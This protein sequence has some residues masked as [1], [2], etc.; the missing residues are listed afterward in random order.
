[1]MLLL[2]VLL[3]LSFAGTE[4]LT[5]LESV[6]FIGFEG[7]RY[8]IIL[9]MIVLCSIWGLGIY[10]FF[11]FR[12]VLRYFMKAKPFHQQVIAIFKRIGQYL[13]WIGVA[14]LVFSFLDPFL[15]ERTVSIGIGFWPYLFVTGL[16]LF[17]NILSEVFKIAKHAR[18][19]NQL[20]I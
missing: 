3:V 12:K 16:G 7:P 5:D 8:A 17:F 11:L 20:T 18:D 13:V 6:S 10:V 14:G 2:A 15:L 4:T 9:R 19:E 1:M